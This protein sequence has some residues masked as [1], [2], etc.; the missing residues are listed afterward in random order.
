MGPQLASH[1]ILDHALTQLTDG[2]IGTH[3]ELLLGEVVET[4]IFPQG[5]APQPTIVSSQLAA[6]PSFAHPAQQLSRQRFRALALSGHAGLERA[7]KRRR[8]VAWPR[9]PRPGDAPAAETVLAGVDGGHRHNRP[10]SL[11]QSY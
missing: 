10:P 4:S 2:G 1:H 5:G 6:K 8:Q 3:G 9:F 7:S 11:T